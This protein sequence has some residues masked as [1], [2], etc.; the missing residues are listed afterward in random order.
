[1]RSSEPVIY[2][3]NN[4]T[5]QPDPEVVE[6]MLPYLTSK[7][8]N[9]S[10]PYGMGK[11]SA[12]ALQK[13][14]EQVASLLQCD[15]SEIIFTSCGTESTNAAILSAI[16]ADPDRQHIVTT[17]VEHS[18]TLKTCEMLAKRGYE[19]TWLGVNAQGQIDP[20]EIER[21]LRPDT[22]LVTVMWANNETGTIFP[23]AELAAI[24]QNKG[25]YFH[26]DA[27]QAIGKVPVLLNGSGIQFLSL[28]GHKLHCPKGV[29]ALYV[30][31]KTRFTPFL[32]GG[33]QENNK[34][35]GTENV[36][37]I[38][39]LGKAC[40]LAEKRQAFYKDQI[41][42][43]RDSFERSVMESI[44]G[45][46]INGDISH[47]LPNTTNLT[48]SGVD[49]EGLL[50]LLDEQNIYCSAGS[51]CT[52]GSHSPSHVLKAMGL[53][54]TQ[55]RSSLRFSVSHLNT[56]E[57]VSRAAAQVVAAASKIRSLAI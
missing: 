37:S 50:M 5:T 23:T 19:V 52:S 13:A 24:A 2:L 7:Y 28:S 27:V 26:T 51:A 12:L 10:S 9:P 47:R 43:L 3:D 34:R 11:E 17:R 18:A 16:S 6:A 54:D 1:M 49:A 21:S 4:A 38:V 20:H 45:V 53:T 35:G 44:S 40:E 46:T 31:R 57:E 33:A 8:G 39:A 14:R 56:E 29:G 32:T 36:A 48:F 25:V 41:S 55:A 30:N 15:A 42:K 22:A